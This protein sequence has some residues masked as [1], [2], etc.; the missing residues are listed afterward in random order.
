[1]ASKY[2]FVFV[3]VLFGL[4]AGRPVPYLLPVVNIS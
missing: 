1:M 4:P 2:S 3:V